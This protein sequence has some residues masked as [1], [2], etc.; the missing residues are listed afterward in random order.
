VDQHR[1][2]V[3]SRIFGSCLA[4]VLLAI[5]HADGEALPFSTASILVPIVAW[6]V[7]MYAL[8]VPFPSN[9]AADVL[10]FSDG[11][12]MGALL[13]ATHAQAFL[14]H[15]LGYI[16]SAAA[17]GGF[18]AFVAAAALSTSSC[19]AVLLATGGHLN[20][21]RNLSHADV[22]GG[23]GFAVYA[24]FVAHLGF[25]SRKKLL[26]TR[27]E[28]GTLSRDLEQRVEER[29]KTLASTNAA[30]SRFVPQEF[31]RALGHDDV[32]STKLGQA[33]ARD[34][35]VLF[36]DIRNFTALSERM[37]PEDTFGFLNSCL[38][39]LGPHVRAQSGFIDKYI[40]DAIMALFLD[41]P[42]DAV[43]AAMAM[44]R[45]LSTFNL[46]ADAREPLA[47]GIGIHTGRVMMGTIGE[48]QRFEATV[49]SDAVNL[50]ARLETLTKQLGCSMLITADVAK[51]L[52]TEQRHDVRSLGTF[53]LKGKSQAVEVIEVFSS[54]DDALRAAKRAAV[55]PFAH[56]LALYKQ[57]DHV[58]ALRVLG[59]LVDASPNDGPMTWW[60][61]RMQQDL[62]SEGP[63][64]RRDVVRLDDK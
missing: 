1:L 18:R 14:L 2:Y 22:A 60:L 20:L 25:G 27:R 26:Q 10:Q 11:I 40:G 37:S 34:V 42:A 28:L 45:E 8:R 21:H 58:N 31:L 61:R 6:P 23:I 63:P 38:S 56:A 47:I 62:A 12:A 19:V 53:A 49:I 36:A 15:F 52:A 50:T 16:L 64:S 57:G 46:H 55:E 32:S 41:S 54:D 33:S 48:E 17:I 39:R 35:T 5:M 44:Q 9:R 3:P 30:I 59:P 51:H 13:G 4:A 24:F 43:H 7:V 29:T